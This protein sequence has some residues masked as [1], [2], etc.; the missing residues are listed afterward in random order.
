MAEMTRENVKDLIAC[1]FDPELTF[2]MKNREHSSDNDYKMM[3]RDVA[4]S[5]NI[6]MLMKVFGLTRASNVGSL[7]WTLW[8]TVPSYARSFGTA[9]SN[10]DMPCL[11]VYGI[12]QDPYF[13]IA[14]DFAVKN[15]LHKPAGLICTFLPPLTG[16]GKM[17][18]SDASS[19]TLFVTLSAKKI[20]E[21]IRRHC[22]SG[23]QEGLENQKRLGANLDVDMAI[24]YMAFFMEDDARI[25][26]IRRLYGPGELPAG[27]ERM[28]SGPVK[29]EM[30]DHVIAVITRHQER[31]A[32]VTDE[33]M[34]RF[35]EHRPLCV[36]SKQE[37]AL[38]ARFTEL[39]IN[40][41]AFYHKIVSDKASA[42]AREAA[43]GAARLPINMLLQ[44]SASGALYFILKAPET[45]RKEFDARV[46]A[47]GEARGVQLERAAPEAL[48]Y[49]RI[50]PTSVSVLSVVNDVDS[51]VTVLMDPA[52]AQPEH[53]R[54]AFH[55]NVPD[56]T[57]I[58]TLHDFLR[59]LAAQGKA[60]G[61]L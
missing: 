30:A 23:G 59:F 45:N 24:K 34:A 46:A 60:V 54:L 19:P 28:L 2:I 31:R 14:R 25:A 44:D 11:I 13:R 3:Y 32:A 57:V 55:P 49:L 33:L 9:F 37:R 8:Q 6:N 39:E 12:D 20:R 15:K 18:S 17:S 4:N 7:D 41:S 10:R 35:Y 27:V 29:D 53:A 61:S 40:V 21:T 51:R 5:V 36:T 42:A 52:L 22:F 1:G 26:E 48:S 43:C 38:Y 47:A 58:I 50:G 56:A 16:D